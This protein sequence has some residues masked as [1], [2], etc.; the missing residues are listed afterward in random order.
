MGRTIRWI[1][2]GLALA[3]VAIQFFPTTLRE[4]P[5]VETEIDVP[6]QIHAILVRSCYDCH[7]NQTN[8]PLYS[9][10]A[11]VSWYVA[12][13]VKEAREEI[14]FSTWNRYNDKQKEHKLEE[15]WEQIEMGKMPLPAYLAVHRNARLSAEDKSAIRDWVKAQAPEAG[16]AEGGGR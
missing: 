6:P 14:N 12:H 16:E 10:F 13:D 5:P 9:R 8:W 1:L 4:N 15:I 2:I 11:P 7:S 3:L